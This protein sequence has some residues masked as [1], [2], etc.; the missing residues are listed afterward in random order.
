MKPAPGWVPCNLRYPWIF[1]IFL[2]RAKSSMALTNPGNGIWL[3]SIALITALLTAFY[4]TRMLVLVFRL[5][6]LKKM[7]T[8]TDMVKFMNHQV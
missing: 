5:L 3:Y 2:K 6:L 8:A 7:I 4:M 1:R